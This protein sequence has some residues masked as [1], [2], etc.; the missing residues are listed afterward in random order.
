MNT[1]KWQLV[2]FEAWKPISTPRYSSTLKYF[3]RK[4][5]RNFYTRE[6]QEIT[7]ENYRK[8]HALKGKGTLGTLSKFLY[9]C[10]NT[11]LKAGIETKVSS[12]FW[13]EKQEKSREKN[14]DFM[15]E[16]YKSAR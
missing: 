9:F 6:N 4:K 15:S 5:P 1:T 2:F 8:L 13:A 16:K 7:D 3:S 14:F 12:C 11:S 10:E